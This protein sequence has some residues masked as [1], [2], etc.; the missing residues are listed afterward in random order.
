M[1]KKL[2]KWADA[3]LY[4]TKHF[5]KGYS[6][7]PKLKFYHKEMSTDV[8]L[9]TDE[10]LKNTNGVYLCF[11]ERDK[12]INEYLIIDNQ[13]DFLY[14]LPYNS[15]N[16]SSDTI[17]NDNGMYC[18]E[19]FKLKPVNLN[20]AFDTVWDNLP[21]NDEDYISPELIAKASMKAMQALIISQPK[22]SPKFA[23]KQAVEYANEL[24]KILST[25]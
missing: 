25:V 22:I 12:S 4:L 2:G 15:E 13:L 11:L 10:E 21:N 16:R 7:K 8:T 14:H 19:T 23:A 5:K 17:K 18:I 6:V 9:F 24:I 1:I 20:E 3:E